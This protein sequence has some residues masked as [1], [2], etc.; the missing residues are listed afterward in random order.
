[1]RGF[2]L[3]ILI[4]IVAVVALSSIPGDPS[5]DHAAPNDADRLA[6]KATATDDGIQC[7]ADHSVRRILCAVL[8]DA[9]S[10]DFFAA[11]LISE[12]DRNGWRLDGWTLIMVNGDDY[13]VTHDF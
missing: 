6:A 13:G 7:K 1:M 4:I 12:L 3:A 5:D 9:S 10:P 11:S 8:M 2:L